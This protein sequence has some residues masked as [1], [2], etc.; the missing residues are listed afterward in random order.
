[1]STILIIVLV[2]W[3]APTVLYYGGP[4]LILVGSSVIWLPCLIVYRAYLMLKR[5]FKGKQNGVS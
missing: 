5:I 2:I 1:M 3:F 4:V